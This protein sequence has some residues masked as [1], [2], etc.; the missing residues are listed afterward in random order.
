MNTVIIPS[1]DVSTFVFE[2]NND[3]KTTSLLVAEKF[4]KQHKHVIR[5]IEKIISQ[6]VEIINAPKFGLIET[7]V[8]V[9]FGTRK[10]KAYEMNKDGFMMVVM[11]YTGE[12]AMKI[13]VAYINAFNAMHNEIFERIEYKRSYG[14]CDLRN[15]NR[16][17]SLYR[18]RFTHYLKMRQAEGVKIS[19][20][21][22]LVEHKFKALIGMNRHDR[23]ILFAIM[24]D[25]KEIYVI[26]DCNDYDRLVHADYVTCHYSETALKKMV[27]VYGY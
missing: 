7:D 24:L 17:I 3:I 14:L 9:G 25:A 15:Q 6:T 8:K 2:Q 27:A 10:D 16:T 19:A 13:K 20:N 18:N 4:G 23:N 1:T 5:D 26:P 12:T 11:G 21:Q 22:S